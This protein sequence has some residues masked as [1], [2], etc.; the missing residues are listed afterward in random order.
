MRLRAL[1]VY[2]SKSPMS[3]VLSL[4]KNGRV[5]RRCYGMIRNMK[6]M[7][8]LEFIAYRLPHFVIPVEDS[9]SEESLSA[10]L[11]DV[12]AGEDWDGLT[13]ALSG[14]PHGR[15]LCGPSPTRI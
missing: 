1:L 13:A 4:A 2:L 5:V 6:E 9:C 12:V 7:G 10:S 11:H 14:Y 3:D 15:N 8:D